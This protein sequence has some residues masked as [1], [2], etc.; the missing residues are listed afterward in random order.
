VPKLAFPGGALIGCAAGVRQRAPHQGHHTA[1]KSGMLAAE[2]VAAAI[3]AGR[4]KDSWPNTTPRC[5]RKLDR[6]RA[7]AGA[8]RP[9]AGGPFGD[10]SARC[11]P[12]PTCGCAR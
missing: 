7:Q 4:E 10:A 12:A 2:A 1:M 8:Q 6:R 5:A 3:A 9:A 11:S